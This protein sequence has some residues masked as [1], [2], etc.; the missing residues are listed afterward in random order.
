MKWLKRLIS[1]VDPSCSCN[2]M[3]TASVGR[4][5]NTPQRL[6]AGGLNINIV[7]ASNGTVAQFSRYDDK[8]DRS[9][10]T[11]HIITD[12]EDFTESISNIISMEIMKT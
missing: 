7:R 8:T 2:G 10:Q 3:S 1:G 11:M 6:E 12:D 9:Y 5:L 4:G